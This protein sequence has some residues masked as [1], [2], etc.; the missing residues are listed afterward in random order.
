[1]TLSY[2]EMYEE[3]IRLK[4]EIESLQN[5]TLLA[6]IIQQARMVENVKK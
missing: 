4:K 3:N 6:N 5:D 1:M 2:V